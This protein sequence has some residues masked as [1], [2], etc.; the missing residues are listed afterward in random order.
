MAISSPSDPVTKINGVLRHLLLG[1]GECRETIKCRQSVVGQ[2]DIRRLVG[3][4]LDKLLPVLDAQ[5]LVLQ[6]SLA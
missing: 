1:D 3:E 2:N 5:R 6:T 4:R